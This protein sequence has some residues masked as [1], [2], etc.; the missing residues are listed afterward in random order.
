MAFRRVDQRTHRLAVKAQ[1][2]GLAAMSG[3]P[4]PEYQTRI[5]EKRGPRKASG[6]VLERDVV[7]DIQDA[8]E[9]SD[10]FTLYRTSAAISKE[11]ERIKSGSGRTAAF[12]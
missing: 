1:L 12:A 3:Q 8:I 9:A 2:E 6:N 11:G 10:D 7:E 5:P 4:K